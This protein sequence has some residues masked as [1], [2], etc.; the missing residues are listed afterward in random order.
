MNVT[1]LMGSEC[2]ECQQC[3]FELNV[4]SNREPMKTG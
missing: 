4:A 2:P 3:G 1:R